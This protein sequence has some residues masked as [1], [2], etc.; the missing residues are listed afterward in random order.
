MSLLAVTRRLIDV[1]IRLA[2]RPRDY[3][4]VRFRIRFRA[5]CKINSLRS[6][7][8][9]VVVFYAN[10]ILPRIVKQRRIRRKMDGNEDENGDGQESGVEEP[11]KEK[12]R[13]RNERDAACAF[14]FSRSFVSSLRMRVT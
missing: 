6:R 13:G 4:R 10:R 3:S 7:C 9:I 1:V 5:N 14:S 11:R 2:D 12:Q 8:V